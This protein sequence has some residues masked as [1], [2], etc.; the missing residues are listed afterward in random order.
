MS[1]NVIGNWSFLYGSLLKGAL[2]QTHTKKALWAIWTENVRKV[3]HD[4]FIKEKT[5]TIAHLLYILQFAY[6]T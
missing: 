4:Q 1:E 6:K 3:L 5:L 2:A